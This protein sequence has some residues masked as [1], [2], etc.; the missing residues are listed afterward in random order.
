VTLAEVGDIIEFD[1]YPTNHSVI[2]A[3]YLYPCI[4]YEDT[5]VDKIGFFSGFKPVD[6]ILSDP[7]KFYL[8]VN[9]SNPI[10]YYCGA[11]GSCIE[12]QMVGVINPNASTSLVLQKQLAANSSF[13]LLPGQ[14]WPAEEED[15]FATTT[16]AA[17]STTAPSTP[18]TSSAVPAAATTSAS[19]A[20]SS[21]HS[22]L[23][24]GAIAGIAIG[25]AA[26]ALAAAVLIYFCGRQSIRQRTQPPTAGVMIQPTPFSPTQGHGHMSFMIDPS[27]HLSMTAS[28][29]G[30]PH[31]GP[32]PALPG[33][34]PSH[35]PAMSPPLQPSHPVSD[36][37]SP[38]AAA[39]I[40]VPASPSPSPSQMYAAP[41]YNNMPA[42]SPMYVPHLFYPVSRQNGASDDETNPILLYRHPSPQQPFVYTAVPQ[43]VHEMAAPD[44][45]QYLLNHQQ[46]QQPQQGGIMNFIRR[47]SLGKSGGVERYG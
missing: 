16:T 4:P 29:V 38:G 9:D 33:Y 47:S 11:P 6:A 10:F 15:P 1:F 44:Q 5:G 35:D 39:D 17:P 46:Q 13:M 7:P 25:A 32:S 31:S 20:P 27:K 2:R 41:A 8:R 34:I 12:Q 30:V 14:P 19:P 42:P 40:G 37:L 18:T 3:E 23:S 43:G 24:G 26:I 21:H 22:G 36:A 28:A 45:M